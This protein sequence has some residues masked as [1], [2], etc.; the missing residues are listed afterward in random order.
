MNRMVVSNHSEGKTGTES[1]KL[2]TRFSEFSAFQYIGRWNDISE[3]DGVGFSS[4]PK[5]WVF[6]VQT[7]R[8]VATRSPVV[9]PA[10][11]RNLSPHAGSRAM[12]EMCRKIGSFCLGGARWSDEKIQVDS[13]DVELYI[14]IY[15]HIYRY[16][17]YFVCFLMIDRWFV[18][19]DIWWYLIYVWMGYD[20]WLMIHDMWYM[21]SDIWL[22]IH[23]DGV[24]YDTWYMM[25]WSMI[26]DLFNLIRD[27]ISNDMIWYDLIQ[28][29][30]RRSDLIWSNLIWYI[31]IDMTILHTNWTY[32]H[33]QYLYII[34]IYIH[35]QRKFLH[36]KTRYKA[37]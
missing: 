16:S 27:M 23:D 31:Y 13:V 15:M 20:I 35:I 22:M 17:L 1:V 3:L 18:I 32:I 37:P 21:I 9:I 10:P 12:R 26:Y 8:W 11:K 34:Y 6:L 36:T 25:V 30:M 7:C 14:Y 28:S 29:D 4:H 33:T 24:I 19:S 5:N 2:S